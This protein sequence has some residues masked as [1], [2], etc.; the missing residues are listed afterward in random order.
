MLRRLVHLTAFVLVGMLL[1]AAFAVPEVR[2]GFAG[3]AA[4]IVLGAWRVARRLP[5]RP[6]SGRELYVAAVVVLI[7]GVAIAFLIPST[8]AF[9]ECPMPLGAPPGFNCNCGIDH[10]TILRLYTGLAGV[11]LSVA[12]AT[13]GMIG[14][15]TVSPA[16]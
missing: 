6:V 16:G 15:R 12:L 4:V 11:G 7:L 13:A 10:H 5:V 2:L 9:C 8:R 3:L 1:L 14:T